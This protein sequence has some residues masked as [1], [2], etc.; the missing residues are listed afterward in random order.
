M[1]AVL[2]TAGD[3]LLGQAAVSHFHGLS[4]IAK[5][6]VFSREW[7]SDQPSLVLPCCSI[8]FLQ[9]LSLCTNVCECM[10]VLNLAVCMCMCVCARTDGV[11]VT[12]HGSS[13]LACPV[14]VRGGL[15]IDQ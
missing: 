15:G 11:R 10:N 3:F 13:D 12:V 6:V 9:I 14:S 4:R 7:D 1:L 5:G 8:Y 2:L